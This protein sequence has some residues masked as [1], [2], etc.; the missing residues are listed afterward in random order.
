MHR[1]EVPVDPPYAV[2][3]GAG[4]LGHLP[5]LLE[6]RGPA[7][8]VADAGALAHHRPA[9]L[10]G[11][12]LHAVEGGE[13]AKTL[14][15]LEQVLEF[16]AASRLDRSSVVV[17]FGGGMV[18]DL[19]GLAAS[20]FKRGVA[21]VH[22]P[23]TLL[24]QVD[25]SVGGKTAVNLAAGKNLVGTFHQPAGVLAD[26]TTLA[27][28][29]DGELASGLGEVLKTA[30]LGGPDLLERLECLAPD[31]VRRDPEALAEIV[32]ACVE[33]KARIVAADPTEQGQRATLN[34]GHTLGHAIEG[35]AGYGRIPHGVAVAA[36]LALALELSHGS[37]HLSDPD[38]RVRCRRLAGALGL[39]ADL[40]DLRRS[41]GLALG[42]DELLGHAA[43]DKKGA[44]GRPRFVLLEAAGRARAGVELPEELLRS[45]LA[46]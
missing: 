45:V 38:L 33:I 6:D 39:P 9:A 20:L 1:I 35:S 40:N 24:A 16:L 32:A 29:P 28:L 15:G 37:G 5:G 34:L 3:V 30:L 13:G 31:L 42:P 7:A 46:P 11:L 25:A 22:L 44:V 8:V 17:T 14:A 26:T 4:A 19:G 36:G 21:V 41:T 12:P 18:S 10:E 27:T 2:R 23:T 43:H